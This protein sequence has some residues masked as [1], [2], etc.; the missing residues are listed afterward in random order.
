[1]VSNLYFSIKD[2]VIAHH[3][4]SID[5]I[6]SNWGG[7][8]VDLPL[9]LMVYIGHIEMIK[10]FPNCKAGVSPSVIGH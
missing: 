6:Y 2:V 9:I 7:L 5:L 8:P 3:T 1:M 4:P 10:M